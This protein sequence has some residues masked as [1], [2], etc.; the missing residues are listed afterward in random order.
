[1][2]TLTVSAAVSLSKNGVSDCVAKPLCSMCC[3]GVIFSVSPYIVDSEGDRFPPWQ[4][5]H[6][7]PQ[8]RSI[9][10][11]VSSPPEVSPVRSVLLPMMALCTLAA[12]VAPARADDPL[13][14]KVRSAI[15]NGKTYLLGKQ[16]LNDGSWEVSVS[17]PGGETSLAILALLTAGVP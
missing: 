7:R 11:S 3:G 6:R 4:L 12:V 13:V 15:E 8:W 1:I 5:R 9:T 16:R 17:H 2:S 14:E 10:F